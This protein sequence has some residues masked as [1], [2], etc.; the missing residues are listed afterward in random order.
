M[1]LKQFLPCITKRVMIIILGV[2]EAGPFEILAFIC[3]FNAWR[4]TSLVQLFVIP[5]FPIFM[6]FAAISKALEIFLPLFQ[7]MAFNHE[8]F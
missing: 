7:K 4:T 3:I 2:L 6:F 1:D 5:Q 8:H